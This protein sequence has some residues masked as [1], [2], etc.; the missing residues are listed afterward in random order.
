[1]T[2]T[3][4][5]LLLLVRHGRSDE[6]STDM[7]E[8]PCGPQWDPPLDDLGRD[9]AEL[10]ARRLALMEPRPV[11]VYCSTLRRARET[12]APYAERTGDPVVHDERLVEAC[13]GAWEGMSFEEILATDDQMLRRF[14]NQDA[15][16]RHAPGAETI[17]QVRARVATAVEDSL[18][19]HPDGNV[20]VVAH[21]GVI[22]AYVG[23][24]LGLDQEMFFL[25]ENTS[26][27]SVE[28]QGDARRVRFLNDDRHL[29]FPE[30]FEV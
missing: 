30:L 21:G 12:I 11:A 26:V 19:D 25:P 4:A 28:V 8:G 27:N 1:V 13:I 20:V 24:V 2:S 29:A 15:I 22:N 14:R 9:Q 23:G 6:S 3:A 16:W 17:E 18:A 7:R 5:R 10:L